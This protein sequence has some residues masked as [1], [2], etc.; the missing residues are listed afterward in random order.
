MTQMTMTRDDLLELIPA[1]ALDALDT[2]ERAEVDSLLTSD[3]EAQQLLADY[4]AVASALVFHVPERT[5]SIRSRDTR[6]PSID[7]E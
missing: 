4:E 6:Y 5:F 1:Y 2:D 7:N 3:A